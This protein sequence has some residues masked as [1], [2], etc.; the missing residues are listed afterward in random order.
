MVGADLG[1]GGAARATR[2]IIEALRTH[3]GERADVAV[4]TTDGRPQFAGHRTGLPGGT[5]R[6]VRVLSRRASGLADRLPWRTTNEIYHSR[7]DVWTGLGGRLERDG[8]DVIN[9]NWL[10]R[11]TISIEEVGRLRTPVVLTLHDM[12]AFC[13]SE[14][15]AADDR[16]QRGYP[17]GRRPDGESGVDW[18]RLTWVRKARS[19][20]RPMQIVT[21]SRWLADCVRASALMSSWPVRV[22]PYPI[23]PEVWAP[24]DQGAARA[25]LGIPPDSIVVLFGAIGGESQPIKGADLLRAALERLPDALGDPDRIARVR[26]VVFGGAE[27]RVEGAGRLPF[28]VQHLGSIVDDRLMRATYAAADVMVV[29][30]RREAFG[31]TASEAQACG[32]PV[33]AFR[34]GG[35]P[36]IIEDRITGRLVEPF[37]TQALAEAMAWVLEDEPRRLVLRDASRASAI[38]RFDPARVAEEYLE[39]LLSAASQRSPA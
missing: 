19:W 27:A 15:Y 21:P 18:N 16:Y 23:D 32:V 36:D 31:Q 8:G 30:S 1:P 35:L 29:P 12:W 4:W 34:V 11:D 28:L 25:L 17:V 22:V 5:T 13:G 2:R 14:H 37:D 10:G 20:R 33:V 7:A 24:L 39:V 9:L 38:D 3:A 26:L 6:A